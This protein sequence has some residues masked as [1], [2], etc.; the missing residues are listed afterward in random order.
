MPLRTE[1]TRGLWNRDELAPWL[2]SVTQ[3]AQNAKSGEGRGV[4]L[5]A[6]KSVKAIQRFGPRVAW[7][8]RHLSGEAQRLLGWVSWFNLVSF[9]E[10]RG[11]VGKVAAFLLNMPNR[12]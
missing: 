3:I 4:S 7:L 11:G 9:V 8:L 6:G 12:V 2:P 5:P 10:G 1:L